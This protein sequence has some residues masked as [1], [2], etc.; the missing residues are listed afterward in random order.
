MIN[1]ISSFYLPL[2]ENRRYEIIKTLNKNINSK[3]I[4][5]IHLFLDNE[6]CKEY[7]NANVDDNE[8]KINIIE[9]YKQ[10]L[11][12]DFFTFANTLKDDICMIANSD[13]WLH[14]I[15]NTKILDIL[16]QNSIF[17]LT[18]HEHD[19]SC[20]LITNYQGSHDAFIFK[21]PLNEKLIKHIQ[22][23]QNVWGSENVLLY[24][25]NKLNY[26]IFNPCKGIIIVHEH[27][28]E[29]RDPTRIRINR[30]D[31]DGDGVY[32]IRSICVI[33]SGPG[34]NTQKK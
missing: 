20:P 3:H 26:N 31:Y 12:S 28:N 18:R 32:K 21:S 33:P 6:E 15:I 5:K 29:N 1:L 9:F 2:D 16:K 4:S 19:T 10:P 30:G 7:L 27:K 24:E 25:L 23:P 8:K 34:F 11:Y 13:I 14:K 22:H 17:A